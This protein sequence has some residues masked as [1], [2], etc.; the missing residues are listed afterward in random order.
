[1]LRFRLITFFAFL[2]I[3]ALSFQIGATSEVS[4]EEANDFVQDFLS[5]TQNIDGFGIFFNNI[6]A[7]LPMFIPGAGVGLG[8][9]SAWSTGFG[10]AAII[11]MAPALA[12]IEPLSILFDSPYGIMELVAYSISMSRSFHIVYSLA[13]KVTPTS[14]IKPSVVEIGIVIGLLLIA[15]FLEEYMIAL[16]QQEVLP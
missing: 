10:F 4:P 3:Y 2:G 9:Y 6:S 1:M 7:S 11:T 16:S 13:K 15:G 5:S 14:L 8:I 12:D